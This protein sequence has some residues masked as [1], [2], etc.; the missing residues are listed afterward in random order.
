MRRLILTAAALLVLPATAVAAPPA[1]DA[2]AGATEFEAFTAGN[3]PA[4]QTA[5]ER[6]GVVD[7]SEA[8]ADA[9]VPRCLGPVSFAKTVWFRVPAAPVTRLVK[10]EASSP[11]GGTGEIPDLALFVGAAG[12]AQTAEAQS[13]DGAAVGA[14]STSAAEVDARVPA[15]RDVLVQVGRS[16]GQAEQRLIASLRTTDLPATA[17]P[18][19]DVATAAPALRIGS[20]EGVPLTGATL[21]EED[22][23]Q[24]A[25]PAPATVWRRARAPARGTYRITVKGPAAGTLTAFVGARPT[26]DGARACVNRANAGGPLVLPVALRRGA[27]LWTRLGTDNPADGASAAVVIKRPPARLGVALA[28]PRLR[29]LRALT[30]RRGQIAIRIRTE[31]QAVRGI[32]VTLGRRVRGR[33]RGV[34][35]RTTA[36]AIAAG[37]SKTVRVLL[38]GRARPGT[39]RIVAAGRAG[40]TPVRAT[41]TLRLR[42]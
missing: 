2:P 20:G 21:T 37:G 12:G 7:L 1:N 42:R 15:G 30:R 4:G 13:C 26:A 6:Q 25:C 29:S 14:L 41:K 35:R 31:G 11:S 34:S 28:T 3:L 32:R 8:T 17:A 9:G 18:A 38:R 23:A 36:N 19:G 33:F 39:Y 5:A 24:P 22:P 27:T 16:G 10:I 40:S